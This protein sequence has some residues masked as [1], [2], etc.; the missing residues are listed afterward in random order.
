MSR[1]I[2]DREIPVDDIED[3]HCLSFVLM[4]SFDHDIVH[5]IKRNVNT[6]VDLNPLLESLFVVSLY[7]NKLVLEIFIS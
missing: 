1:S 7:L 6:C 5:S 2:L 4:D 3:I